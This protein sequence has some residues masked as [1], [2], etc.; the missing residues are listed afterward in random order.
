MTLPFD[1]SGSTVTV[2]G[3]SGFL[4][5][6]LVQHLARRGAV[7]AVAVRRPERA[8]FLRPLGDVGQIVPVYADVTDE[9]SIK[10]A[11]EN[12]DAVINLVGILFESKKRSF[13]AVHR[14]AAG[15]VAEAAARAGAKRLVHVSAL[16]AAKNSESEYA[17]TKARGEEAVQRAFP[18]ATV[19]R[20]SIVFGPE[21]NFFNLFAAI[22]RLSPVVP[23]MGAGPVINRAPGKWPELDLFGRG[24]PRF[25]PVYVGDV[26]EAIA[27]ALDSE[28]A[29]GKRYDLGGPR[30]Y[31]MKEIVEL[32][33]HETGRRRFLMP[34]PF[35][36]L[37][38]E[39][40]LLEFLGLKIITRD[41]VKL[42]KK[43]NVVPRRSLTLADLGVSP[44]AAEI[45]LPTYLARYRRS[46][47]P[48]AI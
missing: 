27:R 36:L 38:F 29:A 12:A 7:I 16:G 37:N 3:G 32:V 31:T 8:G 22:A 1:L 41:Q 33:L 25:Q 28:A 11:V 14:Q 23:V 20:P 45:I 34:L 17:R 44:H 35:P 15:A 43:D 42:L 5:R 39:A 40:A 9:D 46:G 19:M 2:F 6:H 30:V 26:A 24:G 13:D 18:E 10:A 48:Q 21:D 47:R 4:G